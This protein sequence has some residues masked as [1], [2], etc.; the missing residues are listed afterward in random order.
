MPKH[1]IR[2]YRFNK[3]MNMITMCD[4]AKL[5]YKC[6]LERFNIL[7]EFH[8]EFDSNYFVTCNVRKHNN[9]HY[10]KFWLKKSCFVGDD[11]I[12]DF[13]ICFYNDGPDD[14]EQIKF[15]KS[16]KKIYPI[17]IE[18]WEDDMFIHFDL[19][20]YT[21][22]LLKQ[23]GVI[24]KKTECNICYQINKSYYIKNPYDCIHNEICIDCNNK[25][26]NTSKKCPICRASIK[27]LS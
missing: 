2:M 17:K 6:E 19:V 18:K 1:S 10:C 22:P 13:D 14:I 25:I 20:F 27:F 7:Y 5:T 15:F 12:T 21:E 3:Q 9:N 8:K 11:C 24:L 4:S 26:F 16:N 23:H